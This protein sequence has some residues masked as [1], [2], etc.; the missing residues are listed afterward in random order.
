VHE[1][2]ARHTGALCGHQGSDE[3]EVGHDDVGRLALEVGRH[4]L[5]PV[6][7]PPRDARFGSHRAESRRHPAERHSASTGRF[8][9]RMDV[10]LAQTDDVGPYGA[11]RA[12]QV[13]ADRKPRPSHARA[14]HEPHVMP[15]RR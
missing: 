5:G 10:G 12:I 8:I 2:D 9:Q 13:L 3:S 1:R 4:L 7:N 11:K 15:E 14:D 6:W